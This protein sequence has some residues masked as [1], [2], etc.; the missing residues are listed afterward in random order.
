LQVEGHGIK[1][2]KI[3][4]AM[5]WFVLLTVGLSLAAVN[6]A[7]QRPDTAQV[8]VHYKFS[9]VRDTTNRGNPY[10]ENMVL[11][12]GKRAGVYR[13]YDR[14]LGMAAD[15]KRWKEAVAS[16]PN[17]NIRFDTRMRGSGTE[18][19]QY[20]NDRKM[21]R[22]EEMFG[23]F[24]LTD[25]MPVIDWRITGDTASFGG[26]HC[27]KATCHFKGRDYTAWFCPDLP[28]HIGPWKLNG[29][30]GVIVEASDAKGDVRFT[31]DGVEK[32]VVAANED[33][34]AA[35]G[36]H[37]GLPPLPGMGDNN[38]DPAIIKV[39]DNASKTT[40]AAFAKLQEAFQKDPNAFAQSMISAR[41]GGPGGP[42]GD[43]RSGIKVKT[44]PGPVINNPLELPEKQ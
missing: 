32:A 7:A 8:L 31:F 13:S 40:D 19:Y 10:T 16:S 1:L 26:L 5:K 41:G 4:T 23:N 35:G 44:G 21:V 2:L 36:E 11:V 30:P 34:P 25:A 3:I 14:I 24:L 9:H 27:Q 15:K 29:L 42:A 37:H 20:P 39:P 43:T 38:S 22:K 18:Y 12:I 33:Q 6:A 17:G 28:L